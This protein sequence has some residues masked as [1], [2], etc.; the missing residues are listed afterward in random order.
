MPLELLSAEYGGGKASECE[1]S[2]GEPLRPEALLSWARAP[3]AE[4]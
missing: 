2:V 4:V 1:N 3:K